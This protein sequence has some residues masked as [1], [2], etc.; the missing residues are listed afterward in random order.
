MYN[1]IENFEHEK[2][3]WDEE[4]DFIREYDEVPL[5]ISETDVLIPS[6]DEEENISKLI[7]FFN[8]SARGNLWSK[9]YN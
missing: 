8:I 5:W 6:E 1:Y 9:Y 4:P 7:N 2:G 3:D